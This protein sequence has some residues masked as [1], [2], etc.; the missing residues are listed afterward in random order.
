MVLP[1]ASSL[2]CLGCT[3]LFAPACAHARPT[4]ALH[5]MTLF[6]LEVQPSHIHVAKNNN[7]IQQCI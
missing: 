3:A 1:I 2:N 7:K 6:L 4:A 5:T